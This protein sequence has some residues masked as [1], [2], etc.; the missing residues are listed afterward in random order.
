[1][2]SNMSSEVKTHNL[3]ACVILCGGKGERLRPLT[4]ETPKP[5]VH[6]EGRPILSY[7]MDHLKKFPLGTVI[8]AAGFQAEKIQNFFQGHFLEMQVQVVDSGEADILQRI[9]ACAHHISGDFLVLYGD[10]LADVDLAKLQAFHRAHGAPASMCVWPMQSP[11]GVVDLDP[12]GTVTRFREKPR[13][14]SW[15]NI[16]NFYFARGNLDRMARHATFVEFLQTLA[17]NGHLRA[18]QH[19]G[20]HITINTLLD[21]EQ[22]R[23]E[24]HLFGSRR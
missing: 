23:N 22:A 17:A 20:S 7:L 9:L 13:L 6:L 24:I 5:L 15:I 1:M 18:F 10:T 4:Q 11:F 12:Q 8:A 2:K 19:R 16:G 14:E 3:P 21:L